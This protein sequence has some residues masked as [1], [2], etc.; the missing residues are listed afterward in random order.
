M[1][2]LAGKGERMCPLLQ[3]SSVHSSQ[4]HSEIHLSLPRVKRG[5]V[6]DVMIQRVSIPLM[7]FDTEQF[8]G[9]KPDSD[10]GSFS[11]YITLYK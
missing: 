4:Y 7:V 10:C 3:P 6:E 11:P 2:L 8:L 5:K 9:D 1:V